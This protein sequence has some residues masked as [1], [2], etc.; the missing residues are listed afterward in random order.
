M[1][2]TPLCNQQVLLVTLADSRRRR[3][4]SYYYMTCKEMVRKTTK[5]LEQFLIPFKTFFF[6]KFPQGT[7]F[8]DF[9]C[10]CYIF[11]GF[12]RA[13]LKVFSSDWQFI[14]FIS[15]SAGP[16]QL[17]F[18][19]KVA[20]I[21]SSQKLCYRILYYSANNFRLFLKLNAMSN[22]FQ[23]LTREYFF[24]K[25]NGYFSTNGSLALSLWQQIRNIGF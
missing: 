3:R 1:K 4:I 5:H 2:R 14:I 15:G 12:R 6:T 10:Y 7:K 18:G 9:C 13:Y 11:Y 23:F 22:Q 16:Q 8:L 24:L 17:I 21:L 20:R 19:M 25:F